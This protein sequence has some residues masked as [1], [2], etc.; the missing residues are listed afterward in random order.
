[1]YGSSA[2]AATSSDG[3][4]RGYFKSA[5]NSGGISGLYGTIPSA[6]V[7]GGPLTSDYGTT[8]MMRYG[9]A[10]YG[11]LRSSASPSSSCAAAAATAAATLVVSKSPDD[12]DVRTTLLLPPN[13]TPP[14]LH[15]HQ[16]IH[17]HHP[18]HQLLLQDYGY[19]AADTAS[20]TSSASPPATGAPVYNPSTSA[21]G[22]GSTDEG[23]DSRPPSYAVFFSSPIS[24]GPSAGSQAMPVSRFRGSSL[25][26]LYDASNTSR[27]GDDSTSQAANEVSDAN[28]AVY[29]SCQKNQSTPTTGIRRQRPGSHFCGHATQPRQQKQPQAVYFVLPSTQTL[30]R[31][32]NKP[33]SNHV[34]TTTTGGTSDSTSFPT[35]NEES[36]AAMASNVDRLNVITGRCEGETA[37]C[38]LTSTVTGRVKT[39]LFGGQTSDLLD[40]GVQFETKAE[41]SVGSKVLGAE[42]PATS[43]SLHRRETINAT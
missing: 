31:S 12:D 25:S 24:S 15:M 7:S 39:P 32:E 8:R 22:S 13:A 40:C 30:N 28:E 41:S 23:Y 11:H 5:D 34:S 42:C 16:R 37:M 2:V 33:T 17:R 20:S 29:D 1:M 26:G 38:D 14:S 6:T 27:D 19:C 4:R 36:Y 35:N 3:I 9:T 18:H 10:T 21:A 43:D